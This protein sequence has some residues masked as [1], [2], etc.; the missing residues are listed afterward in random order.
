MPSSKCRA[1]VTAITSLCIAGCARNVLPQA[2]EPL[3]SPDLP[4]F[5]FQ[6]PS[7]RPPAKL[8]LRFLPVSM[9]RRRCRPNF[10]SAPLWM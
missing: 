3:R 6:G 9:A 2:A 5:R 1:V 7:R 8:P 10:R 4:P